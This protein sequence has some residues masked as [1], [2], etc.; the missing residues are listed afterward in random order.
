MV[1]RIVRYD[2]YTCGCVQV[3]G[4]DEPKADHCDIHKTDGIICSTKKDYQGFVHKNLINIRVLKSNA[5][6]I[7]N[8]LFNIL[9]YCIEATKRIDEIDTVKE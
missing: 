3:R 9:G 2:M 1:I 5:D 8:K 6:E 4:T 7:N